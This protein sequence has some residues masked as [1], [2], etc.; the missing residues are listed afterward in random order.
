MIY[1]RGT[2]LAGV[3]LT[4]LPSCEEANWPEF[5]NYKKRIVPTAMLLRKQILP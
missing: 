1:M 5:Y 3:S 2:H 4:P